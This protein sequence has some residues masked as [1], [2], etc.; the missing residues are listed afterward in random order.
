M[1]TTRTAGQETSPVDDE[2]LNHLYQGGEL[3]AAGKLLEARGLLER[4]HQLQPKNEK[5]QSLLGLAYFKLGMFDR[6]AELY[7]MLVRDNPVDPTLRVNLGLVYLKTNAL[8]RAVREFEVA[9]DLAPDHKKGHNYLGLALAQQGEYGRAKEHFLL[10]GSDAMAE[11]MGRAIAG[12]G[13]SRATPVPIARPREA[14]EL[15]SAGQ[16]AAQPVEEHPAQ[17]HPVAEQVPVEEAAPLADSDLMSGGWEEETSA[18]QAE[19][20]PPPPSFEAEA[21]AEAQ[22]PLEAAPEPESM[23]PYE[24]PP[25]A[26]SEDDW[27][28]QFGLDESAPAYSEEQ[29][30]AQ[31]E[32]QTVPLDEGPV[33]GTSN[34]SVHEASAPAALEEPEIPMAE[35]SELAPAARPELPLLSLEDVTEDGMPVLTAEPEDAEDLAAISQHEELPTSGAQGFTAPEA[36][37]EEELEVAFVEAPAEPPPSEPA[38]PMEAAPEAP[39]VLEAPPEPEP[40]QEA[41]PAEPVAAPVPL[42]APVPAGAE[43]GPWSGMHVPVLGEL[44]QTVGLGGA[45][46]EGPFEVGAQGFSARVDGELLTRLDGLVAF[47]G[48]LAFKPEMKRFR[49]RTTDKPFGDG[50]ARV[51]RATGRG[52]LFIEP[53]GQRSL[54]A[55]DLGEESAYFRDECVF[56][57]EEPVMFENGRVPSDVAPDLDLVH[58]RGD[59]KV[60]L[61]LAGPLRSVPVR[62]E[63]A[64]TVPLTHLVGWQGNLTPRVVALLVAPGGEVLK[65]AVELSGEGFALICLPVR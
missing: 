24:P 51:V 47:T 9:V 23:A 48:A 42:Q 62:A 26:A 37:P 35:I 60:L 58:L 52:V 8:Q 45:G 34:A 15:E 43:K 28:A 2:F 33:V 64:V 50:S 56:A 63:A 53:A 19:P 44:A 22:A 16:V 40:M 39:A 20:P 27:G 11:K 5:G 46:K 38:L 54:L 17:E 1:V 21:Q 25:A 65:T 18:P 4:A 61:S 12:D 14:S 31:A 13:F 59:G 32:E 6:A 36:L 57:F 55:V 29:A 3:L 7:E 30:P 41:R 10:A 49:G